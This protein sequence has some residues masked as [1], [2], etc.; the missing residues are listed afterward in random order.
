MQID[1]GF[2]LFHQPLSKPLYHSIKREQIQRILRHHTP[3]VPPP[4]CPDFR[5]F[6]GSSG[7]KRRF[8]GNRPKNR[9][10]I[11][12]KIRQRYKQDIFLLDSR[13]FSLFVLFCF[14][15]TQKGETGF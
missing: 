15:S 8:L 2:S 11:A 13:I 1:H 5:F 3:P 12:A 6:R 14:L 10:G 9:L 7:T 4:Q